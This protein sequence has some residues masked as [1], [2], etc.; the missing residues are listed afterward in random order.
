[1]IYESRN[2]MSLARIT[3]IILVLMGLH[4]SIAFTVRWYDENY[5]EKHTVCGIVV[6][7]YQELV[8]AKNPYYKTW[9]EV[10]DTKSNIYDFYV[11]QVKTQD[12]VQNSQVCIQ[13]VKA[14]Y[15]F[16]AWYM[17]TKK[18]DKW[19]LQIEKNIDNK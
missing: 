15:D 6:K 1:M 18:V 8:K 10:K 11:N 4:F 3:V 7:K 9:I 17:G 2:F 16:G 13:F 19:V 12:I 5:K 14:S